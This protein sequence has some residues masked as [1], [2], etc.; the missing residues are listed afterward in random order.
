MS[1]D[2]KQ[3]PE[4]MVQDTLDEMVAQALAYTEPLPP[5]EKPPENTPPEEPCPEAVSPAPAQ[6]KNGFIYLTALFACASLI[7][8]LAFLMQRHSNEAQLNDAQASAASLQTTI[9]DLT[10]ENQALT[11]RI[12]EQADQI[13]QAYIDAAN[14]QTQLNE[15]YMQVYLA[16]Q[17]WYLE[18]FYDEGDNIMA[19]CLMESCDNQVREQ[20]EKY[21]LQPQL[22]FYTQ[23]RDELLEKGFLIYSFKLVSTGELVANAQDEDLIII[24]SIAR[25]LYI[26]FESFESRDFL[27]APNYI[28]DL[29]DPETI[30]VLYSGAFSDFTVSQ[31]EAL[32]DRFL[33]EGYLEEAEDGR[34]TST[35]PLPN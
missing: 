13:Q 16:R 4:K 8:L 35:V 19:A 20:G 3:A 31:Y 10:E 34:L 11:E 27:R 29:S 18:Q 32:R 6:R 26:A 22:D 9:N 5:E 23:Y 7:L 25:D 30:A 21:L 24:R 2:P 12:D 15:L 17:M 14:N 33:E 28:A 1:D